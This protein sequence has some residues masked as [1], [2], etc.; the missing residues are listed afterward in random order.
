LSEP[1]LVP[2]RRK[3]RIL[4]L[5]DSALDADLVCEFL[6]AAGMDCDIERVWTRDGF[7]KAVREGRYDLILADHALPA[8]DGEAALE[9][10]RESAAQ[11]PF[12]FVSGTLGEDV[13]V[14]AMKRG[15]TDYVV[16]QRL[17]RLP[18]VVARAL[19]EAA[20][21][22]ERRRAEAA[23]RESED[24]F[25]MI[26]DSAPA[27][28]W[29]SGPDGGCEF[30]NDGYLAFFGKAREEVMGFGW[31]PAAHPDDQQDYV[32][33]YLDAVRRRARFDA[34]ARFQ[35]ADG[36]YRW[37]HSTG[38]PRFEGDAFVG[39]VGISID[40]T[41]QRAAQ[42]ELKRLNETLESRVVTAIAEREATLAQLGELQKLE[43]LGQLTGGVAHD[44]NNL[45]TPI[46]GSLDLLRR[47]HSADERSQRLIA[48]ALQGAERAKT[49]VARLL[50]FA[51]RQVLEPR[52]VDVASLVEGMTE[53][54][55][56]SIGPQ[57]RIEVD[58]PGRLPAALV[59]PNQLELALLNLAVNARDAMAGGGTLRIVADAQEVGPDHPAGL[60]HGAYVRLAVIDSGIG[61]DAPTLKRAVEPFFSTKGVGKGTGLGL[62]MVHGL[63]AQSGGALRLSSTPGQGTRAEVWLPVA[64]EA[65]DR[66]GGT[67]GPVPPKVKPAVIL[68][69]D[70][71]ELVRMATADM[72]A[73]L[74]HQVI[75][76]SSGAQALELLRGGAMP[77][78]MITDYLM[79]GMTGAD[80]AAEAQTL[81]PALPILLATGYA[82]LAGQQMANLPLLPKPF[83]Q[84]ELAARIADLI[85]T[86]R[87]GRR[88]LSAVT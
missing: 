7:G 39:H 65:A 68:L 76:A 24:R 2:G 58:L 27:L 33:A 59:D 84:N 37:L 30:V 50:A 17:E 31:T 10:A 16:K 85:D 47:Q 3:V 83:R 21:R 4:H 6:R 77:D 63:A 12:V 74:G 5:E 60:R 79:P 35:R 86:G 25:R 55:A 29:V 73:D 32:D 75:E 69:V 48:A 44:F 53:L 26:A 62:S 11:T 88:R 36:E 28:I 52:P 49:L 22:A 42:E 15:A 66:A 41:D 51:R 78:L 71:E 67:A 1:D 64:S 72:L 87:S 54:I 18:A 56:R 82:N 38:E 61:M 80:L 45:L 8:F 19:A 13:A 81:R 70:D 46:V 43:T 9:I 14:E 40:V 23:L 34:Q 57:I 20:E